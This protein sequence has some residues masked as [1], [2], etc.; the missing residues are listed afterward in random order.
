MFKTYT[1]CFSNRNIQKPKGNELIGAGQD[2]KGWPGPTSPAIL[3]ATA[4]SGSQ[5]RE[6]LGHGIFRWIFPAVAADAFPY[7][8]RLSV[9][10]F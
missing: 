9:L 3:S 5:D 7:L 10:P 4:S 2:G 6:V 1:T 8:S